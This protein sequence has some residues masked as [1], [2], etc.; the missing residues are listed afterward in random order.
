MKKINRRETA[1]TDLEPLPL[2]LEEVFESF[3]VTWEE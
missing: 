3:G 2:P 1:W